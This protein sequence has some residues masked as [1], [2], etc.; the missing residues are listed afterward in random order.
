[1]DSINLQASGPAEASRAIRKKLKH[2]NSHQQYRALVLLKALV[3][4]CGQKFQSSFADGHMTDAL[5]N[6][7]ND[8]GAD[9]R[10]KKKLLMVLGSWR[11][12]YKDDPSMSVV[13]GLYRQ[14]RGPGPRINQEELS[15]L[16]GL[17]L[18]TE[19]KKRTDK[20]EAKKKAKL[21]KERAKKEEE[22]RQKKRLPFDFE[23]DKSK[24][25]SSIVEA[26]QAS[27]NLV[28]A[29]TLVNLATDSL[30]SNARVQECL[31]K[32]NLA[33][34]PVVRYI[35][36]VENDEVIGTLIEANDRIVSALEMYEKL[37]TSSSEQGGDNVAFITA[38]VAAN[39]ISPPTSET[40]NHAKGRDRTAEPLTYV[41]AD[42]EDI[43]FDSLGH[44]SNNLPAPLRPS[45][46]LSDEEYEQTNI[47]QR[48]SLSDFSD[49]ESSNE[50]THKAEPSSKR[51]YVT[52]SDNDD[53]SHLPLKGKNRVQDDPFA[54][55]FADN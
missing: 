10:V 24:V 53:D 47:D 2:G 31:E 54:D 36:L 22:D 51:N 30:E 45:T 37:A 50:E 29:I 7:A 17:S 4:N 6:L 35:R 14:C 52:I 38:G 39:T 18:P 32:A 48:G 43:N 20:H 5:K 12:Q 55:P 16:M 11:E 9:K 25:L 27:S 41:F 23:K 28:N 33:K 3:E 42:L 13:A 44:S 15:N 46:A 1:V 34:K 49:Y 40:G 8:S 21:E 19:E 26:S